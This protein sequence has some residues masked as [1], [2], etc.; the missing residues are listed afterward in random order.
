MSV[1]WECRQ[2]MQGS[3]Q[4]A[5]GHRAVQERRMVLE[6]RMVVEQRDQQQQGFERLPSEIMVQPKAEY[7]KMKEAK[8]DRF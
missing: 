6:Q 7:L 5:K 1:A 4:M 2:V 3:R 8:L